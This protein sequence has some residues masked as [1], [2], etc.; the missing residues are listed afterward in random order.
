MTH[1]G[2]VFRD[3]MI[4]ETAIKTGMKMAE[5]TN[6]LV[7]HVDFGSGSLTVI[8][9]EGARDRVIPINGNLK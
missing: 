4:I 7:K 2:S 8:G 3:L 9:E 5:L 6:L 1:K